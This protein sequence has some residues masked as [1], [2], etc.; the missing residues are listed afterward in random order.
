MCVVHFLYKREVMQIRDLGRV[1]VIF[2][3]NSAERDVSLR[4][5]NAVLNALKSSG[6]DAFG[7]DLNHA[8]VNKIT[9]SKI[10]F[11]FIALHGRG[12]EDGAIQGFLEVLG[13]PYTGS[14]I[15]ASAIAMN[16]L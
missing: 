7:I 3:G 11:A 5:G 6:F 13:I 2:G 8:S 15:L 14:G 16:K 4:S 9:D 10:D 1:A 12:G